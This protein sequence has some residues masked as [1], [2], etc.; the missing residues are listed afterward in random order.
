MIC[1]TICDTD[2][3]IADPIPDDLPDEA[4]ELLAAAIID[5]IEAETAKS[6]AAVTDPGKEKSR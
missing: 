1:R 5:M 3:A 6:P 2:F 4:A